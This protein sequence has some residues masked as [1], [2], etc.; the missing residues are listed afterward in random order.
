[1]E[2]EKDTHVMNN[3][4][5]RHAIFDKKENFKSGDNRGQTSMYCFLE[6]CVRV[7]YHTLR[8]FPHFD[9]NRTHH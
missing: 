6:V 5:I 8:Y 3:V 9:K 7:F 4:E 2:N 1:M